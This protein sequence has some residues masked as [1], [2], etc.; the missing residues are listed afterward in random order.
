MARRGQEARGPQGPA[1][2]R[3][4][5]RVQGRAPGQTRAPAGAQDAAPAPGTP[6]SQGREVGAKGHSLWEVNNLWR[7]EAN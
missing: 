2:G 7:G 3:Q 5:S 6:W 1:K 4:R